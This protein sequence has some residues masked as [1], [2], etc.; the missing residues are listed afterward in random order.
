MMTAPSST[1]MRDAI[2]GFSFIIRWAQSEMTTA[3]NPCVT[4]ETNI[5]VG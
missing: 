1:P 2:T 4:S 5:G 3:C